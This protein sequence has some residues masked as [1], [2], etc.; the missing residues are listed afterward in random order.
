[1]E[2][3]FRAHF[4]ALSFTQNKKGL[5]TTN[6]KEGLKRKKNVYGNTQRQRGCIDI[7]RNKTL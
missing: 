4:P 5:L 6:D 3:I 1:M 7:Y 2:K